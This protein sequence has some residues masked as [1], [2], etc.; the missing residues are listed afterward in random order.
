MWT[1]ILVVFVGS[2]AVVYILAVFFLGPRLTVAD[3]LSFSAAQARARPLRGEAGGSGGVQP[4]VGSSLTRA[5]EA[6]LEGADVPI[7]PSEFLA[8]VAVVVLGVTA[9]AAVFGRRELGGAAL[10]IPLGGLLAI[11]LPLLWL[12]LKR[13][14]RRAALNRQLPDA[15][16]S[17]SSSLRAGY[18]FTQGMARVAADLPPPISLEFARAMREMNLGATVEDVLRGMARRIAS[19]DFDLAVSGILINRQVG[20]NLA[21][22]LDQLTATIR[23]RVELK[24]FVRIRTAQQRLSAVIIAGVPPLLVLLFLA[25]LPDYVEYLLT[26]RIGLALIGTSIAMQVLGVYFIRRIIAI[27]I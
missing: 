8:G 5:I 12:R 17:V 13:Y 14:R 1:L 21:G 3:R 24:N 7:K 2:F 18:G 23:E 20:G 26:T 9:V 15:L 6:L 27:D 4:A 22:L 11:L 25:G 16:Q 19:L 10:L